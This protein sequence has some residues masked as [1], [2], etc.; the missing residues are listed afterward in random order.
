MGM[1]VAP[2]I[3]LS[4]AERARL[5][6]CVQ[7][8][9]TEVRLA[10]RARIVLL[11]DQGLPDQEIAARLGIVRQTAALWRSRYLAGGFGA[12]EH[13]APGRGRRPSV[14][15]PEKIAEIVAQRAPSRVSAGDSA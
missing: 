10:L 15:L 12:L 3:V 6:T 9:R 1:R 4:A 14:L 2:P 7:G 11:A 5:R 13:D 8:K